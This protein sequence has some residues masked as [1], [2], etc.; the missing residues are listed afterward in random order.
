MAIISGIIANEG[1]RKLVALE[2]H[3]ALYDV[4]GHLSKERTAFALRPGAGYSVKPMEPME[5]RTFTI[6]VENIETLWNPKE[7]RVEITG[8]KYE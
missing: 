4:Y 5:R 3:V 1:D 2:L 6:G 8:L 7:L